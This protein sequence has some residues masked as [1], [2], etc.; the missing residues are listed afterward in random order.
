MRY[1]RYLILSAALFS[2][3]VNVD[4]Q[5]LA[6]SQGGYTRQDTLRGSITP[7]RAWWDL[8]YYHLDIAVNPADST[9]YGS[10]TVTYRVKTESDM[11]QIDLQLPLVLTKAEQNGKSLISKGK[12]MCTGYRWLNGRS[13]GK[14]IRLFWTMA[15]VRRFPTGHRGKEG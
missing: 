4:S 13:P 5:Y 10:N 7:E 15:A 9:I 11:M 2:A 8:T 1:I 14:C 12:G 3:A 6:P